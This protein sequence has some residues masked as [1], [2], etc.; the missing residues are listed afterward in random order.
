MTSSDGNGAPSDRKDHCWTAV[1]ASPINHI[2]WENP[3]RRQ[4]HDAIRDR[5]AS[6]AHKSGLFRLVLVHRATRRFGGV[7]DTGGKLSASLWIFFGSDLRARTQLML[8]IE[9]ATRPVHR[10]PDLLAR[11]PEYLDTLPRHLGDLRIDNAD[12]RKYGT[13]FNIPN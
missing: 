11:V 7:P 1:N 2:H 4:A 13:T 9:G 5:V 6:Y 3:W 8:R 10:I 12:A